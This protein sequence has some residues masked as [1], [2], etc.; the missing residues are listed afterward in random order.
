[1]RKLSILLLMVLCLGCASQSRLAALEK[2]VAELRHTKASGAMLLAEEAGAARRF[3]WRNAL[4]GAPDGLDQIAIANLTDGDAAFVMTLAAE[5]ATGYLYIYDADGTHSTV[6]PTRIIANGATGAW[7][8]VNFN[9]TKITTQ[10]ADGYRYINVTNTGAFSGTP[11]TGD[12]YYRSGTDS[13]CC[14]DG[15]WLCE[16]LTAP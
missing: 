10:T 12:C 16:V 2:Q 8:L 13:W 15:G 9:V 7:H 4:V 11:A 6:S 5:A 3:W 14:Y 1:M